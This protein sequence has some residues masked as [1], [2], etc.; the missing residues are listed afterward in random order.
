MLFFVACNSYDNDIDDD[1]EVFNYP[2]TLKLTQYEIL[3]NVRVFTKNGE[4]K[5]ENLINK[6]ITGGGFE[7]SIFELKGQ[8]SSFEKG[9]II[10]YKTKDSV[11]F[12]W[13]NSKQKL[14]VKDVGK[15]VYFYPKDTLTYYY[16]NQGTLDTFFYQMGNYK[17]Y[18]KKIDMPGNFPDVAVKY[19]AAIVASGNPN[20]L[21]INSMTYKLIRSSNTQIFGSSQRFVLNNGFDKNVLSLLNQ[22]D[23]IAVQNTKMVYEKN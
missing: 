21:T 11:E 8:S 12:E 7:P 17:P 16:A 20:K 19:Y 18:Y 5:N 4:V 6:F 13:G 10:N 14:T 1:E 2:S 15:E 3:E 9:D 22:G 23:T